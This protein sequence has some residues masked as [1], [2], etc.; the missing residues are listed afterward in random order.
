MKQCDEIKLFRIQKENSANVKKKKTLCGKKKKKKRQT[1][2][3]YIQT[4]HH[5]LST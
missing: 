3:E 2:K 4:S 5:S 1:R